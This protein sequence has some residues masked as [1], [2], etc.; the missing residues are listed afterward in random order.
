M[1]R[2]K[3][4][5]LSFALLVFFQIF[6]VFTNFGLAQSRNRFIIYSSKDSFVFNNYPNT[7]YGTQPNMNCGNYIPEPSTILRRNIAFIYFDT[8]SVPTGWNKASL[9][10][11]VQNIPKPLNLDLGIVHDEWG[12][13]MITW[14]N[15]PSN[16]TWSV[17]SLNFT[18]SDQ[19]SFD[20]S[21]LIFQSTLEFSIVIYDDQTVND[22]NVLISTR[23]SPNQNNKPKVEFY[24]QN[25]ITIPGYSYILITLT[26]SIFSGLV[27]YIVRSKRV[28]NDLKGRIFRGSYCFL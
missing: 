5:L 20:V 22:L 27:W 11:S 10:L 15:R 19:N 8:S 6:L 21:D 9:S 2:R 17:K 12:E 25:L 28:K 7:N 24:F 14:N 18:T 3:T 16:I 23:E 4:F 1:R 13:Y 26:L